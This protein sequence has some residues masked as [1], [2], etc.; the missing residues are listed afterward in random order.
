MRLLPQSLRYAAFQRRTSANYSELWQSIGQY[1]R[2]SGCSGDF[3]TTYFTK[4]ADQLDEFVAEFEVVPK[5]RG[6]I[7]LINDEVVGVEIAPNTKAFEAIWEPA[8]RDCYGSEAL[9]AREKAKP[10]EE[11]FLGDVADLDDLTTAVARLEEKERARVQELV[12]SILKQRGRKTK[13]H[14]LEELT[15]HDVETGDYVGFGVTTDSVDEGF[16]FLSL[17]SKPLAARDFAFN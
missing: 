8:I 5:Q 13:S 16:I 4:Y 1:N 14:Q 17:I 15:M 9:R 11:E 10:A 2:S 12:N 6:A 7:V 3:L